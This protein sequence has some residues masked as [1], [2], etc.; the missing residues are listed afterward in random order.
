MLSLRTSGSAS[1]SF[2]YAGNKVPEVAYDFVVSLDGSTIDE[3]LS[4]TKYLGA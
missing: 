2:P 1:F 3:S 4:I